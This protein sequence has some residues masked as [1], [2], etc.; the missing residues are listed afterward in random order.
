M[1]R[2]QPAS[3]QC[4]AMSLAPGLQITWLYN[5]NPI[6]SN[7]TRRY[8]GEDG[9]LYFHKIGGSKKNKGLAGEY[10]CKATIQNVSMLSN[11]AKL[12]IACKYKIFLF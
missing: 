6:K 3:L 7:D 8:V 12:K 10:R 11:P 9:S 5:D 1:T 4:N 2:G